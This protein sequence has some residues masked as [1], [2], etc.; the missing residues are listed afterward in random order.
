L[1]EPLQVC[2]H[3]HLTHFRVILSIGYSENRSRTTRRFG[4]REVMTTVK[5]SLEVVGEADV[6][7]VVK[8]EVEG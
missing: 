6:P 7:T 4:T 8:A 2:S 5:S 3:D 1:K